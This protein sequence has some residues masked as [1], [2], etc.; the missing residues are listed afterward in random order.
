MIKC[1]AKSKVKS[2]YKK[3]FL[4]LDKNVTFLG[5]SNPIIFFGFLKLP[6]DFSS[7][8]FEESLNRYELHNVLVEHNI[9][10]SISD[11]N[12]VKLWNI[13][14]VVGPEHFKANTKIWYE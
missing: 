14:P 12:I 7:R 1:F 5:M 2:A 6:Y 10:H 8:N 4:I 11:L 13:L 9:A 3:E